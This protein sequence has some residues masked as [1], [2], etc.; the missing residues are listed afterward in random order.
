[1][2]LTL[3]FDDDGFD[4]FAPPALGHCFEWAAL[5]R[6]GEEGFD[7]GLD[8]DR[9]LNADEGVIEGLLFG[10]QRGK[11]GIRGGFVGADGGPER[12][13][14]GGSWL[15]KNN[16]GEERVAGLDARCTERDGGAK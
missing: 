7:E 12:C 11:F 15:G 8:V 14:D 2:L 9:R 1:L 16:F 13:G 3:D 5:I 4:T 6:V 10:E